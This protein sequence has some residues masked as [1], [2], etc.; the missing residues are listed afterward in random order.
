MRREIHEEVGVHV[1]DVSVPRQPGLAVPALAD[2]GVPGRRRPGRA[3]AAG[4][5]RD[6]RGDVGD[7]RGAAR[8]PWRRATGRGAEGSRLLLPGAVSHRPG[9]A[10]GVGGGR[11]TAVPA[12]AR[13]HA[14]R[15][16]RLT[17]HVAGR[18]ACAGSATGV[19]STPADGVHGCQRSSTAE[20]LPV[21][22]DGAARST[23][24]NRCCTAPRICA[25]PATPTTTSAACCASGVLGRVRRG[26]YVERAATRRPRRAPR[27]CSRQAALAELWLTKPSPATCRRR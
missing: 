4:R 2:G 15:V 22:R 13:A 24:W 12:R 9:D 11:L 18:G 8:M 10:G 19:P 6:R 3:L 5:R 20:R 7:A 17:S 1:R 21:G 27:R 26:A 23:A 25:P 16:G 14:H